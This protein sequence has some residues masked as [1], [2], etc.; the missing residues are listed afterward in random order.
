MTSIEGTES[1]PVVVAAADI[2]A[3]AQLACLLEVTAPKPGNVSPARRFEDSSYED[4]LASAAAIGGPLTGAGVRPLGAT[5]RL[6]VEATRRWTKSN[7]NLGLVLLLAPLA[8][9]AHLDSSVVSGRRTRPDADPV[10]STFSRTLRDGLG[11]VLD[12]TTVEDARNVYA[13]IR[14]AAPGG[15]GRVDAQDI[16]NDPD[17]TLLEAMRLAADRD[18]IAREYT[19]AFDVTFKTAVPV[20]ERARR[21]GLGWSDAVV[22]TYLTVLASVPDTHVARRG[23]AALA[24]DVSRHARAVLDTGGVRSKE[25][26]QAIYAMDRALRDPKHVANPGTTA[27]L[28]AA[29]IFVVLLAG[30]WTARPAAH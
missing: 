18:G 10:V 9:A 4:F 5:I 1:T 22:E 20:L 3:A 24:D 27:D 21:D 23:G 12:T 2:A 13:A 30:G 11:G 14:C 16:A 15:L 17:V 19:T 7:T 28:T 6:A 26:R 8:R 29:A 25:G